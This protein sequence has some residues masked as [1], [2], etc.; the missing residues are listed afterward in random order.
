MALFNLEILIINLIQNN[1]KYI[2]KI[3][4][5]RYILIYL[6]ESI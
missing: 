5:F 1:I 6:K 2:L 3:K 4:G